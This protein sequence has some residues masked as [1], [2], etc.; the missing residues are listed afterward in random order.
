[1]RK[2]LIADSSEA[3]CM[4]LT[5]A[6]QDTFQIRIC[7]DGI[8][9]LELLRVYE[10][11]VL[12]LDLL[13][14]RLDGITLLQMAHQEGT[15]PLTLAT[16]FLMNEYVKDS[17]DKFHV[18]Y[19]MVK[20]CDTKALI[21][22]ITDMADRLETAAVPKVDPRTR[23]GDMLIELGISTKLKG[24]E[25]TRLAALI[26]CK[27]FSQSITKELYPAVAAAFGASATQVE[28]SIRNAIEIA[29]KKRNT[30]VWSRYFDNQTGENA[31]KPT[32]AEFITRLAHAIEQD[33]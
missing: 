30:Q 2:I 20:P 28:R 10:P 9:A 32:N 11:D 24:F 13:L 3:L 18:G 25:Y 7:Q 8:A 29:W 33:L 14:P 19:M 17:I 22:R 12:V 23:I 4:A 6:L 5:D 1:M 27:D 21:M 15:L 16:T 26:M 31:V